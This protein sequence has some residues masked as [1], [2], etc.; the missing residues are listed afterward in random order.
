MKRVRITTKISARPKEI[1]AKF[2]KELF[3]ELCPPFVDIEV[4]QFDGIKL[5]DEL[6]AIVSTCGSYQSWINIIVESQMGEQC[7]YFVDEAREM[8]A[9][10]TYWRHLHEVKE[11]DKDHSLLTDEIIFKTSTPLTDYIMLVIIYCLMYF[12]KPIYMDKLNNE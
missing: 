6:H 4:T 8:P 12:R 5:N 11:I 7:C 3:L 9:P 2:N 1:M 10:F